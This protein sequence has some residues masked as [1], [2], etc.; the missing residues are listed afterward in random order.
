MREEGEEKVVVEDED[1]DEIQ[2]VRSEGV[3]CETVARDLQIFVY[4]SLAA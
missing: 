2:M 3:I 1:E 4:V